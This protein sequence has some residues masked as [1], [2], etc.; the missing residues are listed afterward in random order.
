[1]TD[2]NRQPVFHING[3]EG[4]I[5]DPNG[6]IYFR[7]AYH[8]FYQY[9]PHD[10]KWG[11]MHWGHVRSSDLTHWER[12][13]IALYPDKNED[14][15]FSG[16]AIEWGGKL[17]LLYTGFC[18]N[19][20]GKSIRQR[21]CL[22]SSEDG[23]HFTKHGVVIGEKELPPEFCPWDFRDPKVFRKEDAFYCVVAARMRGGR[24]RILLFRSEDLF[25]WEFVVDVLGEDGEGEMT[26]CP[27]YRDDIGVLLYSGQFQPSEGIAHR[28]I[29][30]CFAR[31]GVLDVHSGF[32]GSESTPVDYGFDFYAAQT[33]AGAPIM[34]GWLDM[35][36]RNN[37]TRKYGWAGQLSVPRRVEVREGRLWQTPVYAGKEILRKENEFSF[38]DHLK[39]GAVS[40]TAKNLRALTVFLHKKGDD[41]A[42]L[43]LIGD[44][45]IFDR[46]RAGEKI[47]GAEKDCDSLTG[48]RRMPCGETSEVR[49]E[50]VSDNFSVE[51][52]IG[53]RSLSSLLCTDEDADGLEIS[54]DADSL[55][56]VRYAIE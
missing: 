36:D 22:A 42:S 41:A 43:S 7:G 6:L 46:S 40:L 34:I 16:S 13:P 33:F 52:F 37:P 47:V 56:Y 19:E 35:W 53:G 30:S 48:I 3:G 45:W 14:G 2:K 39:T 49:I 23:V 17:W 25:H 20:G 11:P 32:C 54:A 24:G 38:S 31:V 4:W 5:N 15:C 26:E 1:M 9:Y 51:I 8:V 28:N 18:E 27:D 10:T 55:T 50:I 44:E 12:L 29:H 21:Q